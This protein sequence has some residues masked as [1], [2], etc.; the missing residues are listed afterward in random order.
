[1]NRKILIIDDEQAILN[2]LSATLTKQNQ[3]IFVCDNGTD[4]LRLAINEKPDLILLDL[5]M[6]VLDGISMLKELRKDNWGKNALVI[7]LTNLFDK[8]KIAEAMEFGVEQYFIKK[9]W[10]MSDL[11]KQINII[12]ESIN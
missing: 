7:V 3:D 4:G 9:D 8:E 10:K 6:P 5:I 2:L 12:L 1:M 11:T